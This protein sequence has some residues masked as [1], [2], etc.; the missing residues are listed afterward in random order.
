V[1]ASFDRE[2]LETC[3]EWVKDGQIL[4][5]PWHGWEFDLATGESVS[6]DTRMISYDVWTENG[7][8]IVTI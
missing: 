6:N 4:A 8:I 7:E 3:H 2:T 5:C 1:E